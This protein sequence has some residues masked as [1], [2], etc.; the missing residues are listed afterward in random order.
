MVSPDDSDDDVQYLTLAIKG[1]PR[2][3]SLASHPQDTLRCYDLQDMTR[4]G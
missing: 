2:R 1:L 3:S 4:E